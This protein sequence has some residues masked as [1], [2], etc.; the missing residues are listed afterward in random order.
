MQK[1]VADCAYLWHARIAKAYWHRQRGKQ[2][3]GISGCTLA[4]N[5]TAA[6]A[7][8]NES[9]ARGVP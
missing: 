2:A 6:S 3:A 1:Q 5:T 8:H 9:G 7:Q 4:C